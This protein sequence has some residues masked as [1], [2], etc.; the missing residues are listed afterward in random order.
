M[1][2]RSRVDIAAAMLYAARKGA[3]KTQVMYRAFVSFPQV[4]EYLDLLIKQG[5]ME[6]SEDNMFY[7]TDKGVRF[8]KMYKDIGWMIFP[9]GALQQMSSDRRKRF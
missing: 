9:R 8:L 4:E 1:K 7:T 3:L 5:M 6:Y 2:Y